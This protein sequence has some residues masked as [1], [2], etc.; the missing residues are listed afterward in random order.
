MS[1]SECII[2][3]NK[4]VTSLNSNTFVIKFDSVED[5]QL[6]QKAQKGDI[7]K[8]T[9]IQV[10]KC[11]F[12][13]DI[14]P[15]G[16]GNDEGTLIWPVL[17]KLP[18]N[19][20]SAV[21]NFKIKCNV[22]GYNFEEERSC[23]LTTQNLANTYGG[24]HSM[25]TYKGMQFASFRL[26][27]TWQFECEIHVLEFRCV[28]NYKIDFEEKK[29]EKINNQQIERVIRT[30]SVMLVN[31]NTFRIRFDNR[32]DCEAF[33]N[34]RRGDIITSNKITVQNCV[35]KLDITPAGWGNLNGVSIWLAPLR[36]PPSIHSVQIQFTI[37]CDIMGHKFEEQKMS[38]LTTEELMKQFGKRKADG[39]SIT[40]DKSMNFLLF[41]L[42][43]WWEFECQ[44]QVLELH[45]YKINDDTVIP[46]Q[47][48]TN[49]IERVI[50]R[51]K[52]VNKVNDNVFIIRFDNPTDCNLFK[53]TQRGDII[54][55]TE[56]VLQNCTFQFDVTPSGWGDNN[57]T[58]IWPVLCNLPNGVH[59]ALVYFKM[60]C[61]IRNI[62]F[63]QE[64]TSVLTTHIL[65]NKFGGAHSMCTYKGM[66][67]HT[68][69]N[70]STW[71]FECVLRV[72][73]FRDS[74][75]YKIDFE[76]KKDEKNDDD[77]KTEEKVD[78]NPIE[79]LVKTKSVVSVNSN[80]YRIPFDTRIDCNVFQNA[81]RGDIITTGDITVQKC[82]FRLD[83]T[84][85]GWGDFN[86][87]LVWLALHRL[88]LFIHSIKV[89]FKIKCNI[90]GQNFEEERISVLTT[91]AL[92][93]ELTKGMAETNSITTPKSL[94]AFLFRSMNCWEFE[95]EIQVLE[96]YDV[97]NN[98]INNPEEQ[99]KVLLK[100]STLSVQT[101]NALNDT[102][103]VNDLNTDPTLPPTDVRCFYEDKYG[104]RR[105]GCN[106]SDC[107]CLERI[108]AILRMYQVSQCHQNSE[109][110]IDLYEHIRIDNR[111]Y[112]HIDLLNDYNHLLY[113]HRTHFESI[114][115]TLQAKSNNNICCKLSTC[116]MYQRNRR[117]RSNEKIL[118]VLYDTKKYNILEQQLWDRIHSNFFHTF[119]CGYRIQKS[120][121]DSIKD[122]LKINDI[123]NENYAIDNIKVL[124]QY[125]KLINTTQKSTQMVPNSTKFMTHVA[126]ISSTYFKYSYGYRYFYWKHYE[127]CKAVYDEAHQHFRCATW[128]YLGNMA[129]IR[130]CVGKAH[131]GT[132]FNHNSLAV[133]N[134]KSTVDDW[135]ITQK[136]NTL[137]DEVL[138]N[139]KCVISLISFNQACEKA[140]IHQQTETIRQ[141]TCHDKKAND[142]INMNKIYG[143]EHKS[144]MKLE[145]VLAIMLQ[146]NFDVYQHQLRLTFWKND[147]NETDKSLKERHRNF[148][149]I[150]RLLRECVEC[151]GFNCT[152]KQG[153]NFT[154]WHGISETFEF[155]SMFAYIK[156]PCSTTTQRAVAINFG[157]KG[158]VLELEM[159]DDWILNTT[160]E[161][162]RM[163][164]FDCQFI[165]DFSNE[166]EIFSIGGLYKFIFTNI[167]NTQL[168]TDA[169]L[170]INAMRQLSCGMSIGDSI[171]FETP[172]STLEK[173]LVFRLIS[174]E[175]CRHD[176]NHKNAPEFTSCPEYIQIILRE[177]CASIKHIIF[178][179]NNAEQKYVLPFFKHDNGWINFE[180]LLSVFPNLEHILYNASYKDISFVQNIEIYN[181]LLEYLDRH[182]M[183]SLKSVEVKLNDVWK[184]EI[185]KW[186]KN[187]DLDL[188]INAFINLN[189]RVQS[190]W[191]TNNPKDNKYYLK[192]AN[193]QFDLEVSKL[194]EA[195]SVGLRV[196]NIAGDFTIDSNM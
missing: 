186:I 7:I 61:T 158:M 171:C 183:T 191:F 123:D 79:R 29:E 155:S 139:E 23:I 190:L 151:F 94:N 163:I 40:T 2:K 91:E 148:Y 60:K 142:L 115:N 175:I 49:T 14:T 181:S 83:I 165:S 130:K 69:N 68:F 128:S 59:S 177:H 176:P 74:K 6:F 77:N 28:Q 105:N 135:Y 127:N 166:C 116:K 9:Q 72:E 160:A 47:Q 146:C 112:N 36:L 22:V 62:N 3:T 87:C 196:L 38:I 55:S 124:N 58:L 182:A 187:G 185:E 113:D 70:I 194:N 100:H 162:T 154:V 134:D 147:I 103:K 140:E 39:Y 46:T 15:N 71:Q 33:Q 122:D 73:E 99:K 120:Q 84:P 81:R 126:N 5:C 107:K 189:W 118:N 89:K 57:E 109:R 156:G 20:Y 141:L 65:A 143:I 18:N 12:Q 42:M 153:E 179:E 129:I 25:T 8:T 16:W 170:Y 26:A 132:V 195:H 75:N 41:K 21:I 45:V 167:I 32:I 184:N 114:Y 24:L 173:Q 34:A 30:K 13:F 92:L 66:S 117:D 137:K 131:S 43:N 149:W 180:L 82:V 169:S 174:H 133:A 150:S 27:N 157:A 97:K 50:Q 110:S 10:Q 101:T 168:G 44:I 53:N 64:H 119:D 63:E 86:G 56:I 125:K 93:K 178:S 37:K 4:S 108:V 80:V 136:Y 52:A 85:A 35:F 11:T 76:E 172:N 159:D 111:K 144:S 96:F 67:S 121:I 138:N 51:N 95:C 54:K 17:C 90:I 193:K 164:G 145:H 192:M 152:L 48:T 31:S 78:N 161:Q 19:V 104:N 1:T 102:I 98:T 188:R 106:I 88:P